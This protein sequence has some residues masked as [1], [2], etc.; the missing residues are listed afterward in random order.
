MSTLL[1]LPLA[2][3]G[4]LA[5]LLLWTGTAAAEHEPAGQPAGCADSVAAEGCDVAPGLPVPDEPVV[6]EEEEPAA[7]GVLDPPGSTGV[8]DDVAAAIADDRAVARSSGAG[9]GEESGGQETPA[10][11]PAGQETTTESGESPEPAVVACIQGEVTTLLDALATAFDGAA[12][13]LATEIQQELSALELSD[14]PAL[15]E[16]LALLPDRIA[17][18]GGDITT[19]GEEIATAIEQIVACLATLEP[20]A[21]EPPT[22]PQETPQQETPQQ[23]A[24]Q[25]VHYENCDDARARGAAPVHAGQP[26]YRPA[27]DSDSDGVGCE[28]EYGTPV[29]H[30]TYST[31]TLAYTGVELGPQLAAGAVLLLLGGG[32]LAA[33]RR[34]S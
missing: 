22:P 17:G 4:V 30:Q 8:L 28:Q 3:L 26:G 13:D 24:P 21:Q 2:L 14:V 33:T 11:E 20:P 25:P 32:L 9:T 34:R 15:T 16:F 5:L 6:L 27:L 18:I 7:E 1:R 10:V 23:L 31:G 19:G 12:G 29:Q